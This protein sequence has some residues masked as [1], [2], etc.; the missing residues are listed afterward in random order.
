MWYLS[1][2]PTSLPSA[3]ML[4]HLLYLLT[5]YQK[6]VEKK[7][8]QTMTIIIQVFLPVH[9]GNTEISETEQLFTMTIPAIYMLFNGKQL[10]S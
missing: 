3:T 10:L 5:M 2:Y 6:V 7:A 4:Y 1:Q 9:L 8:G